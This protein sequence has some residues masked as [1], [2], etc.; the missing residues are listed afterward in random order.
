MTWGWC[1]NFLFSDKLCTALNMFALCTVLCFNNTRTVPSHWRGASWLG[2]ACRLT[3]CGGS[4]AGWTDW[5]STVGRM[6]QAIHSNMTLLTCL[7]GS[8]SSLDNVWHT[9]LAVYSTNW[10][11]GCLTGSL[12]WLNYCYEISTSGCTWAVTPV[13]ESPNE[14]ASHKVSY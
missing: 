3:K 9:G 8:D 2:Q 1:L 12:N 13:P 10:V 4:T 14:M 5:A 6:G 11:N 7:F